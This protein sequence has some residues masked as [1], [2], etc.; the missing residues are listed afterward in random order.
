MFA[1]DQM[2]VFLKTLTDTVAGVFEP[3][4]EGAGMDDSQEVIVLDG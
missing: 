1:R 2:T 4:A 3:E